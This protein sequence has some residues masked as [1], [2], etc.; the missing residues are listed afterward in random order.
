MTDLHLDR[1]RNIAMRLPQVEERL[2]HSCPTFFIG[3]KK[4]FVMFIDQ[5][6]DETGPGIWCAAP[7][8]EQQAR[9][10]ENP[11]RYFFPPYVGGRGWLGVRLDAGFDQG[12]LEELVTEAWRSVA[13]KRLLAAFDA[14]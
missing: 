10:A 8:G 11:K 12:E 9:I 4:T 7:A 3:G 2:S 1:V 5:Y 6:R 14:G 13:P